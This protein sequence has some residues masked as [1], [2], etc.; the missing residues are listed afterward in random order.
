MQA[1]NESSSSET[2]RIHNMAI[3]PEIQRAIDSAV[4][5]AIKMHRHDGVLT[6][7]VYMNQIIDP[8]YGA[9][10][11]KWSYNLFFG[12]T[13]VA[14]P[15]NGATPVGALTGTTTST[16]ALFPLRIHGIL[17]VSVDTVAGNITI[18]NGASTVATV[19]KGTVA[20]VVT[21]AA[22][23]ANTDVQSNAVF[24]IE[25]DGG[26]AIVIINFEFPDN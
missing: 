14:R 19:A 18:K 22:T 4:A 6:Q 17:V 7:N 24:T 16:R 5:Q 2:H 20:G 21:G 13:S 12:E 1:S 8:K 15:T 9:Y 3:D 10:L 11:R 26:N 25:S 23:A